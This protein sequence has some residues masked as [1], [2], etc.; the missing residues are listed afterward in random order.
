MAEL[1]ALLASGLPPMG[2]GLFC[3]E[4]IADA[5]RIGVSFALVNAERADALE[6][7]AELGGAWLYSM[8]DAWRPETW[9]A[10]LGELLAVRARGLAAGL[11]IHGI[12]GNGESGWPDLP[13]AQRD[14]R[15]A[16]MGRELR[17]VAADVRVGFSTYPSWPCR[18]AFVE[19]AGDALFYIPQLYG[20]TSQDPAV[21]RGWWDDWTTLAG[22]AH[23][24]PAIA[25]WPASA[26][27]S[28]PQGYREY[29]A[30]LPAASGFA[31]WDATGSMPDYIVEA[32][33]E[34][35][36]GGSLPGT[37]ALGARDA[38]LRPVALGLA[39]VLLGLALVVAAVARWA[40]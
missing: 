39:F 40:K 18:R 20:R 29:L 35:E 6:Q 11:S 5:R 3:R 23:C 36:P 25:A 38:L 13:T 16:A 8:P 31:G 15:A 2:R 17:S 7:V 14:A 27:H 26:L 32:L 24:I 10:G 34:Y 33:R 19:A 12:V 4:D 21:I 28:T 9:E 1:V 22:A 30:M 37:L